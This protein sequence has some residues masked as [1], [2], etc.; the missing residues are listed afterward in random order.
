MTKQ[1]IL[2]LVLALGV[3]SVFGEEA[4][5]LVAPRGLSE[6]A[7]LTRALRVNDEDHR[8]HRYVT[9]FY[10]SSKLVLGSEDPRAGGGIRLGYGRLDPALNIG[11]FKGELVWEGYFLQTSSDG[12]NGDPPNI[13]VAYGLLASA[14]YRWKLG[15]DAGFFTSIGFGIQYVDITTSD[16]PLNLNTTPALGA[17]LILRQNDLEYHLG[18]Q[19]LHVSNGGRKPPNPGQNYIVFSLGV[20]F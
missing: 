7:K 5:K 10:G 9:L 18:I 8:I 15:P 20:R 3:P 6:P 12:V 13:T 2:G 17:G 11:N 19:W 16:L 14:L 4:P 1:A